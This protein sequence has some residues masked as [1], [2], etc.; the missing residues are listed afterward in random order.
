[1][2]LLPMKYF[3][4]GSSGVD[5]L[6]LNQNK[7]SISMLLSTNVVRVIEC[8]IEEK[9]MTVK[10]RKKNDMEWNEID[11]DCLVQEDI[12]NLSERGDRWEGNSLDGVPFGFGC[13]YNEEN[14]IV[15]KGFVH[16]KMRVCYGCDYY[17]DQGCIE[18]EGSFYNNVRYG[19]GKYYDKKNNCTYEG[20]WYNDN[21]LTVSPIQIKSELKNHDIQFIIEE[22]S[23]DNHCTCDIEDFVL[24]NNYYLK[25]IKIGDAC[26]KT[27]QQVVLKS[28]V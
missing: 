16:N 19:Y 27:I 17:P 8:N 5:Y 22:L 7:Y 1:M 6:L 21:L 13:F 11:L 18:Y 4:T 28:T 3:T 2:N 25:R 20:E 15:Y 14:M 23:I 24:I 12:I 9:W 10:Q 26:L